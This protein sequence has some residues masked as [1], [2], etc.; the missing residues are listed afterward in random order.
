M[1][2]VIVL[3]NRDDFPHKVDGVEIITE[4]QY[5]TSDKY[6]NEK[7]CRVY[8]LSRGYRYQSAGYYVS[9]LAEAR[10]H[11]VWPT[12]TTLQ[13][14]RSQS[15]IR[16]LSDELDHIIQS[17]LKRITHDKFELSI[18]FGKNIAACYDRLSQALYNLF[19][20]PLLRAWFIK[21]NDRWQLSSLQPIPLKDVPQH[22]Q[23]HLHHS[24]KQ[25]FSK[26]AIPEKK[27]KKWFWMAILV[28]KDEKA[29]PSDKIAIKRFVS[30]ARKAGI[31]A[32]IITRDDFNRI[33]EYDALFIRA[34]T[35]V[36]N[37][38]YR[39]ARKAAAEGLAVIDDPQS[40][41]RCGNKV[42]LTEILEKNNIPAPK[43][44]AV[45][46]N[47]YKKIETIIG[48]PAVLKEPDSSFSF[49]VVKVSNYQELKKT[50]DDA[51]KRSDFIIAQEYMPTDFDWRIG[52]IDG[53]PL[54]ACKYFMARDHWQIYNW[55]AK[56][57][58]VSGK[59]ETLS[60]EDAPWQAVSLAVK[61]ANLIGDGFYGIDIK[62]SGNKFYVIEI[63]DN[64][65]IESS[66][67]DQVL[68]N[69]LYNII[70]ESFRNRI[71][72]KRT[73]VNDK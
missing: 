72:A 15:I 4:N 69:D 25:Y 44:I 40:I 61:S 7:H 5:L 18:Y 51:F 47:N 20:A 23:D 28:D 32:E 13:D 9:L 60:I 6:Q 17:S 33:I 26:K 57:G 36:N 10:K 14:F 54:F 34:T 39:F 71:I 11:R 31:I 38:T 58:N 56:K 59:W 68:K 62:Q 45:H 70:M 41:V 48:Y 66:V 2:I 24:I 63:N 35:S 49:G 65:S 27:K 50:I 52:I 37:F 1:K 22:H 3:S 29:P 53:K 12:I 42:Y 64:P 8:N 73:F 19:E 16:T 46:R 30:A 67:E 43:T 55:D 21:K